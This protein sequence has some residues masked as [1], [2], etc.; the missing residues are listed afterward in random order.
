MSDIKEGDDEIKNNCEKKAFVYFI[1]RGSYD[2]QD[3]VILA[4]DKKE[5]LKKLI[6]YL[7]ENEEHGFNP[8]EDELIEKEGDVFETYGIDG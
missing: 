5:A 7:Q 1:Y 2:S 8:T 6:K 3:I 4:K